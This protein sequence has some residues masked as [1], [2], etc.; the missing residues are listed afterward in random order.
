MTD[1]RRVHNCNEER[2]AVVKD[3]LQNVVEFCRENPTMDAESVG[4]L[5]VF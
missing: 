3:L 1:Y 4:Q 2:A 5:Q